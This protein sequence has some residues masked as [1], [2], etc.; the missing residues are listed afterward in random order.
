M[1][2]L[3]EP[4]SLG[5]REP[6]PSLQLGLQDPVFGSQILVLQQQFLVHRPR[7]VGQHARELHES[8]LPFSPANPRWAP[9]IAPKNVA[10]D[11]RRGYARMG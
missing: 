2:N 7:D 10:D 4:G 9:V 6:H 5:V 3:T 8:P 11:T 1:T